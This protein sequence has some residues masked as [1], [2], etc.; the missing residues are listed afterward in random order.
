MKFCDLQLGKSL[1]SYVL[2]LT[3]NPIEV[4]VSVVI[5]DA[6][7]ECDAGPINFKP[8]VM[9]QTRLFSFNMKNT[10]LG[11]VDYRWN[12]Q[13]LDGTADA[14]GPYSV[15]FLPSPCTFARPQNAQLPSN[16]LDEMSDCNSMLQ[17]LVAM[18]SMASYTAYAGPCR[19]VQSRS[20]PVGP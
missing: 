6:K 20:A 8:T 13:H 3:Y 12:V 11:S 2:L 10:G 1:Q 15:S 19:R 7:V 17:G 14:S 4:Q 5:D 16:F 18:G 9:F